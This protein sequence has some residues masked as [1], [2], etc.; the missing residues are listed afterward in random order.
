MR[1]LQHVSEHALDMQLTAAAA[2]WLNGAAG[3][4]A[5]LDS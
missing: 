1:V 2:L 4:G 5:N 3:Q